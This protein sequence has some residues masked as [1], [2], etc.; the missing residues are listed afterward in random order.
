MGILTNLLMPIL[1]TGATIGLAAIP[2][3][4]PFLAPIGAGLMTAGQ[5]MAQGQG[6]LTSLG[7]GAINAGMSVGMSQLGDWMQ[8]AP[9]GTAN[10]SGMIG[11]Y[12]L[13]DPNMMAG[14]L[15]NDPLTR[16]AYDDLMKKWNNF[17]G[18]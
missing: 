5:S 15:P 6:P 14:G 11:N 12:S 7:S 17:G 9:E 3:A 10:A 8:G 18:F 13:A 4:G 16:F 2:G 1:K